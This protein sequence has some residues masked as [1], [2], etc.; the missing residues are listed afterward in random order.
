MKLA[1]QLQG[2]EDPLGSFGQSQKRHCFLNMQIH[3]ALYEGAWVHLA[4]FGTVPCDG[5]LSLISKFRLLPPPSPSTQSH[6]PGEEQIPAPLRY[7]DLCRHVFDV[8][9]LPK[10]SWKFKAFIKKPREFHHH[11]DVSFKKNQLF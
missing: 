8:P 11:V 7:T 6:T 3:V 9:S 10:N 2:G 4:F 5:F 1:S